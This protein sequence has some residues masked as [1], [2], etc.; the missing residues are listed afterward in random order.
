MDSD[1]NSNDGNLFSKEVSRKE[2]RKLK[3]QTEN[4]GSVWFGFGMFGMIG[5]SVAVPTVL[6]V[7]LGIWLDKT[8]PVS[9]SWTL[10]F[11]FL[12]LVVGSVVAWSWVAKEDK[13]MHQ[14]REDNE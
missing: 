9:F 14:N 12:G 3:A 11:L 10:T 1:N 5:W 8:Y 13:G 2:S 7:A 4:S 6:G